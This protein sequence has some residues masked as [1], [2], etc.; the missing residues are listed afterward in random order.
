MR[1]DW[2]SVTQKIQIIAIIKILLKRAKATNVVGN[3]FISFNENKNG[4]QYIS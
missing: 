2:C 3:I 1:A 4:I